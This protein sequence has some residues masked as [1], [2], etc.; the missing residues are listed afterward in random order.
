MYDPEELD[1]LKKKIASA[2]EEYLSWFSKNNIWHICPSSGCKHCELEETMLARL[3]E[4]YYKDQVD[5]DNIILHLRYIR[6]EVHNG[7]MQSAVQYN[8]VLGLLKYID[9]FI[10]YL[11]EDMWH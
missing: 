2:Y 6:D 10:G 1:E 9:E 7:A 5:T 8:F 11:E 4:I 3:K